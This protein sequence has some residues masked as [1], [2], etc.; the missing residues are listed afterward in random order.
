MLLT[1]LKSLPSRSHRNIKWTQGAV[2]AVVALLMIYFWLTRPLLGT[3]TSPVRQHE[4]EEESDV[5]GDPKPRK[6]RYLSP[7][8]LMDRPLAPAMRAVPQLFHQSWSTLE[9]PKKFTTW[10]DRCRE[11]HPDWEWVLWTDDDNA[12]LFERFLPWL[13]ESFVRLPGPIYRADLARNAY[14]L[15]FGGY[16]VL[17]LLIIFRSLVP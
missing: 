10:S 14:M 5:Q 7:A 6:A 15:L 4:E 13:V 11:L 17:S 8:E 16:V 2:I 9:L 12:L 1:S 3:T